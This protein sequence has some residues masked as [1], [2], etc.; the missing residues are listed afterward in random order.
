MHSILQLGAGELAARIAGGE[1]SSREVVGAFIAR[2]ESVNGALNAIVTPLFEQAMQQALA[3]DEA[4][5]RGEPLGLLH[6]APITV[7]DSFH[8][9]G[10]PHSVGL[11]HQT[12]RLAEQD[13]SI[14]A[15]LRH[16]GAI[17]VGKTN[18]SQLMLFHETDNPAYGRTNNPWDVARTPGGSSGGEAAIIAA[19]GSPL[20]IGGDM[21]GSIRT[22]CHFCGVHGIKPTSRRFAKSGAVVCLR[23]MESIQYQPG[24]MARRVADLELALRVLSQP[25][26][27]PDAEMPPLPPPIAA[28]CNLA[29]M[30]IGYW[31]NDGFHTPTPAIQ[32]VVRDA[33][34]ILRAQGATVFET[35]PPDV[36]QA[37][38]VYFGLVSA[39]GGDS[40]R[41]LL[42]GSEV[43][44][45][46]RKLLK[47][48]SMP[49]AA[50]KVAGPLLRAFGKRRVAR[51]LEWAA[52]LSA[53]GYWRMEY[54]R[55]QM[56]D[57][58]VAR[59]HAERLDAILCPPH[60]LPAFPHG[61][62]VEAMSAASYSFLPNLLGVPAGVVA[63]RTVEV[64]PIPHSSDDRNT[65]KPADATTT[66]PLGVQ[67]LAPHWR[68]DS[69]LAVMAALESAFEEQPEYPLHTLVG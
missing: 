7:K 15:A 41:R 44:V 50:R 16:A 8:V 12:R 33:A 27:P 23:G 65:T 3:A 9:A 10:A 61:E 60:A 68:D 39:D 28:N 13:G 32:Q 26:G 40:L 54:E 63:A 36:E 62:S 37:M 47:L 19:G 45:R 11:T 22:P 64:A 25:V 38:R 35:E 31:T 18:V 49:S 53:A 29:A 17:I 1:L 69:V 34:D 67:V 21:G 30:R 55:Q 56:T 6:G 48:A 14:V 57:Q 5:Q 43:D 4:Q 24:P 51:L 2:I 58:F 46:V 42:A 59:L 52:P 20:G 66:L